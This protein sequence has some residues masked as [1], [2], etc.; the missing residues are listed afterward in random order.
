M[1]AQI[2]REFGDSSVFEAAD[3]LLPELQPGHILINVKASSVNPVDYKVR[4][5]GPPIAPVLPAVLHADVAGVVAAVGEGVEQFQVG[6]EV[7]GCAGGVKGLGGALA[8]VM[9]ADARLVAKKPSSL[10]FAE[11]AALPLV[12]LTAWEG[13][14]DKAKLQAGQRVLVHGGTGG[15]GHIALQLAKWRGAHVSVTASSSSKLE[16]AKSLG[17]DEGV[18]YREEEVRSYVDRLTGGEGFDLVFDSTGGDNLVKSFEATKLNGVVVTPSSSQS[19]DLSVMHD[20][21]LSLHVVFMLIPML[22]NAGRERHGEILAEAA[23]L[24]DAGKLR[25]LIDPKHF[26]FNEV[27]RAHDYL[28]Q[29]KVTGKVVL[30]P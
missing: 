5:Y 19:Y 22:H 20:K 16:I 17:A 27:G 7:Y 8:D 28:E 10:N 24:V 21:G 14:I 18:N 12:T 4:R 26:R 30:T 15:V 25:P 13:L 23:Q 6:N 9:L 1:Q 29:G 11:A 2:I 3:L